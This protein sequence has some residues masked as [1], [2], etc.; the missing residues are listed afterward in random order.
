MPEEEEEEEEEEEDDIDEI[1]FRKTG[2]TK[3]AENW[4][5]STWFPGSEY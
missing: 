3:M 4:R 5:M 2:E 1:V